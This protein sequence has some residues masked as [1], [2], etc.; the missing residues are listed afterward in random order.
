MRSFTNLAS[1]LLIARRLY[2]ALR[3]AAVGSTQ[4]FHRLGQVCALGCALVVG[5]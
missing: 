3:G 5:L 2:P 4:P 1:E